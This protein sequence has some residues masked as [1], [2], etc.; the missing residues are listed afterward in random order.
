MDGLELKAALDGGLVETRYQPIVRLD[1]GGLIGLEVLARL[2]HPRLGTILPEHF[3]PQ[4]EDAGLAAELTERVAGSAFADIST[5]SIAPFDVTIGINLPLD[6][7]LVP[8]VLA[9]LDAQRRA[10]G[11]RA[12]QVV[13]ELTES[14]PVTD[15]PVLRRATE[16][17]RAAGYR[18]LIDDVAPSVPFVLELMDMAFSG[19]KLDKDLVQAIPHSTESR[20]FARRIIA[21][22]SAR[23]LTVTAEGVE[24]LATWRRMRDMGAHHAQGFFVAYPLAAA[25]VP[26]WILHWHGAPVA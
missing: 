17:F 25:D 11:L 18:A 12:A 2:N 5:A 6:V 1:T 10:A 23:G 14:Q 24:D 3:V 13:I 22:A 20:A 8:A 19:L 7:L 16:R 4:L 15:L 26:D 21:L 9:R